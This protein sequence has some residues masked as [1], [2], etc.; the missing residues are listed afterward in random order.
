MASLKATSSSLQKSISCKTIFIGHTGPIGR[1]KVKQRLTQI[2]RK[3]KNYESARLL[4]SFKQG[5]CLLGG[6]YGQAKV[7]I[8]DGTL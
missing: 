8:S 5:H 1:I 7:K 2:S 3:V 6:L 4:P